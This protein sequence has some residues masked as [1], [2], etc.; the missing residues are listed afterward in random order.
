MSEGWKRAA[1]LVAVLAL[2]ILYTI[3]RAVPER[4][5][6][7]RLEAQLAGYPIAGARDGGVKLDNYV[8]YYAEARPA[9]WAELG[10]TTAPPRSAPPPRGRN[11]IA[12]VLVDPGLVSRATPGVR[13]VRVSQL[14]RIGDGGCLVV[15]V[16]YD[17]SRD[18]II[19]AWCN[20]SLTRSPAPSGMP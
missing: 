12:G 11:V 6:V 14:P 19:A 2:L 18:D 10:F 13:R 16:L 3:W 15:N 5:G 1:V 17:P 4:S 20:G 8:R 7:D 9:R